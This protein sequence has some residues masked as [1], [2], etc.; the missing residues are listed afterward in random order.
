M[1]KLSI[2]IPTY[3]RSS[4]LRKILE[5]IVSQIANNAI[6]VIISD[7]ASTDDTKRIV[8]EYASQYPFIHYYCNEQNIG[9]DKNTLLAMNYGK[10]DYIWL[11]SDDDVIINGTVNKVMQTI[12]KC[13]PKFIYLNHAGFTD[14]ENWWSVLERNDDKNDTIYSSGEKMVLDH[15]ISH[16]TASIFHRVSIQKYVEMVKEYTEQDYGRGYAFVVIANHLILSEPGPFVYI[17][18]VCVA[19]RNPMEVDY[20]PVLIIIVDSARFYQSL[21]KK[22]L[23]STKTER[24]IVQWFIKGLYRFIIPMRCQND[25]QYTKE[26]ERWIFKLYKKY[27]LFYIYMFPFMI[28]PRWMLL[29]LY[30]S[31]RGLKKIKKKLKANFDL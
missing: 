2:C 28:F 26:Y 8:G 23:I 11:C 21:Q 5:S 3:N 15:R 9:L 30:N 12:E 13:N 16:F 6:E 29:I 27:P 31:A 1:I 4:Y 24:Y 19:V 10:G 22:S 18:K 14:G 7:N 17:G 20:N 25:P